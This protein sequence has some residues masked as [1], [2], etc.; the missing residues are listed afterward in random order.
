MPCLRYYAK[1][2]SLLSTADEKQREGM[3]RTKNLSLPRRHV[4]ASRTAKGSFPRK[5]SDAPALFPAALISTKNFLPAGVSDGGL[6]LL[7]IQ[8]P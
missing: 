5:A 8:P 6:I 3:K 1:E 7:R 4:S 2:R